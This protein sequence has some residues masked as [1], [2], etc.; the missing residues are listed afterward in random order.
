M[1]WEAKI[2]YEEKNVVLSILVVQGSGP[3]IQGGDWLEH[4]NNLNWKKL[5]SHYITT[6]PLEEVLSKYEALFR[7]QLGKA[8]NILHMEPDVIPQYSKA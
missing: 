8:K 1:S 4:I 6:S 5:F 7:P 3:S 2:K